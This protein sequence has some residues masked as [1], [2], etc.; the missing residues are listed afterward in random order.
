MRAEGQSSTLRRLGAN[1]S[2]GSA[3]AGLRFQTM[4][5]SLDDAAYLG[6]QELLDEVAR[7]FKGWLGDRDIY[8][9]FEFGSDVSWQC[10][11]ANPVGINPAGC[12]RDGHLL[13]G[14]L[15]DDQRS[16]GSYAWPP[17]ETGS[18][19]EGLQGALAQAVILDSQGY[20]AFGWEDQA[21][22]RAFR[23]L[24]DEAGTTASGDDEWQPHVVNYFYGTDFPAA[25]PARPGK[26][27]GWT[28]WTLSGSVLSAARAAPAPP[29]KNPPSKEKKT[30]S[31]PRTSDPPTSDPSD[32][33]ESEPPPNE[34]PANEA[35][36]ASWTVTCT[37]RACEF[38][39]RGSTDDGEIASWSWS[40]GDGGVATGS[41]TS[42]TY[43]SDGTYR[44]ELTVT[45][46]GGLSNSNARDVTVETAPPPP[47]PPPP[48]NSSGIWISAAEIAQLPTSGS[49]WN[50]LVSAANNIPAAEGGHNSK[51]DVHTL[52]AALVAART[53]DA[54]YRNKAEANL[55]AAIGTE[56]DGNALSL[57]RNLAAYV[58]AADVI[59]YRDGAFVQWVDRMRTY[60]HPA[61]GGC[62][63]WTCSVIGK[64]ESRPNNHGSMA[65]ASR[66]AAS[67][68]LGDQSDFEQA[69]KVLR[70]YLGD[71]S[72]YAS[73]NYGEMSWQSN[74]GS[75]AGINPAG[76]KIDGHDVDGVMPDDQR[77]CGSF[78]WPP[79]STGYAW[80]GLQGLMVQAWIVHRQGYDV[81]EWS[82]RALLRAVKW[83][84]G[85]G[86]NTADG[87]DRFQLPLIDGA[88]NTSYWNGQTVG[89][90][91]NMGWT[92]WT[93][94]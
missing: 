59:G 23:W 56:A 94:R 14:I 4:P 11:P 7:V 40:F 5:R 71:R 92:D 68:Y 75:P 88:Y 36:S 80:E 9:G 63:G 77:R 69:V 55:A 6:D 10:D 24:H 27:V 3:L 60:Q 32:P 26:N 93:H 67:L 16:G 28:D 78:S 89:N 38:D 39:G 87:D 42:H 81:F 34:P 12:A 74:S 82:D 37:E 15:P 25:A 18:V 2:P 51:H 65:G 52:A 64:H 66:M 72:A 44:V 35:P 70:G 30:E 76:A 61:G 19:Y 47:P 83:L 53:G 29:R 31:E 90:G 17:E 50:A 49:A 86:G 79:C 8:A 21:L 91:K 46:N 1:G 41:R 73:F 58:I 62:S 85:P 20:D 84:Y 45:D 22:L 54:S 48:S 57:A 13:D 33:P 43:G